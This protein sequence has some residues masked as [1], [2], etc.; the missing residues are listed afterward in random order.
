MSDMSHPAARSARRHGRP[1]SARLDSRRGLRARLRANAVVPL[2]VVSVAGVAAEAFQWLTRPSR[3]VLLA[4]LGALVAVC[5]L[6]LVAAVRRAHTDARGLLAQAEAAEEA[7]RE[8]IRYEHRAVAERVATLQAAVDSGVRHIRQAMDEIGRGERPGVPAPDHFVLSEPFGGLSRDLAGL[9]HA[10]L[11]AIVQASSRQRVEID[12]LVNLARRQQILVKRT[13]HE[14]DDL[15]KKVEN[16]EHLDYLWSIDHL[17]TRI[18]REVESLGVLGGAVPRKIGQDVDVQTV[19]RLATQEVEKYSRVE[20]IPPVEGVLR[21]YPAAEVIHLLAELI[22]NATHFSNPHLPVQ[23]RARHVRAGLAIDIA[24]EGDLMDAEVLEKLNRLLAD[25]E[26]IDIGELL[27]DGRIGMFVTARLA[28]RHGIGVQLQYNIVGGITATVV[29]PHTLLAEAPAAEPLVPPTAAQPPSLGL[30]DA[31]PR[32]VAITSG[33]ARGPVHRAAPQAPA[34]PDRA[35][36]ASAAGHRP[37][38]AV[39]PAPRTAQDAPARS[40]AGKPE[41]PQRD[42]SRRYQAAPLRT[43]ESRGSG[44]STGHDPDFAAR[45]RSGFARAADDDLSERPAPAPR[46]DNNAR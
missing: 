23:L 14:L 27:K 9:E 19:L 38:A 16:P 13:L 36:A 1:S 21:G 43:G 29:L 3:G 10:A 39:P 32:P 18:R 24:D 34:E 4:T 42:R 26:Q 25:P 11:T 37:E 8:R 20:V 2:V 15:E 45:F 30:L 17:V 33:T 12:V 28:R 44:S 5:A 46:T 41:L 7:G 35:A 6:V 22:E 31:A 40:D